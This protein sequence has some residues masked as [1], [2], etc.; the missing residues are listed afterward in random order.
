M[1]TEEPDLTILFQETNQG[2]GAVLRTGFHHVTGQLVIVQDAD[3]EY[4]PVQHL[5]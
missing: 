4:D 3:L 1:K 2:K 5:Q